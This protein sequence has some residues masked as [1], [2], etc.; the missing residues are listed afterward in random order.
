MSFTKQ[1]VT[2]ARMGESY[3]I[4]RH[5]SGLTLNLYPMEGF[6][7]AYAMLGTKY[8]SVDSI[9]QI[10]DGPVRRNPEGIAHYL[11]HKMFENEE[12][13]AFARYAATGASANAFTSFDR[14]AYLFACGDHFKESL[15]ILLDFVSRPYFTKETVQKEQG[16]IGQEIKMYDDDPGWRVMFNLLEA[17]YHENTVRN[18]IAGTVESISHI[19]PELLYECYESFYNPHNMVL[20]V[21]GSF[22]VQTVLDLVEAYYHKEYP[23]VDIRRFVP[24]EPRAPKTSYVEQVL[25]VSVPMFQIGFKGLS[26]GETGNLMAQPAD[27][28]ILEMIAGDCSPLYRRLYDEGLINSTFGTEVMCGRDYISLFFSGESEDP[29]KVYEEI[30]KE[31]TRFCEEEIDRELFEICKRGVYGRYLT[32]FTR[33]DNIANV[34]MLCHFYGVEPYA[35]VDSLAALTTDDL[36]QRV[37]QC[38]DP[39]YSALSVVKGGEE[40]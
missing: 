30:Q 13:D 6:S 18:D 20:T 5:S 21:A 22:E 14:T 40:S 1:T 17:L 12:G 10:G 33:P 31:F 29:R 35:L 27:E 3:E 39:A 4:Y 11:E 25:P 34:L 9:Y 7:T 37:R 28:I 38:Y 32:L 23:V 26:L 2:S 36:K 15:E 19:T 8:G 24:D 16:I